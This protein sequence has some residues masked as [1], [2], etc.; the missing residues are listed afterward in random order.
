VTVKNA[1]PV[2]KRVYIAVDD[3]ASGVRKRIVD[4]LENRYG[5]FGLPNLE[6]VAV[7]GPPDA[8]AKGLHD[9]AEAGAE[10]ILL[11]PL[12][13]DAQQMRAPCS[14]GNTAGV[15]DLSRSDP[16]RGIENPSLSTWLIPACP[17]ERR[18]ILAR[19]TGD[20]CR[21]ERSYVNAPSSCN[22]GGRADRRIR[23]QCEQKNSD[24]DSTSK[25]K[26]PIGLNALHEYKIDRFSSNR[27]V[28]FLRG[29]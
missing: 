12:Y 9:V 29:L 22:G 13:D 23:T 1:F 25:I 27:R 5:Y 19:R 15:K 8:C 14:R 4:A 11:N 26:I 28:A 2:A 16:A 7:S 3:D 20:F 10:A 6:S 17:A 21:C 18:S 24:Q